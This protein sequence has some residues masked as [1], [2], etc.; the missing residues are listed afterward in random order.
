MTLPDTGPER[1]GGL[2]SETREMAEQD[3][4]E[5]LGSGPRG[6]V[7]LIVGALIVI[8]VLVWLLVR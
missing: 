7:V 6:R 3:V 5:A 4:M 8:A 1:P 2:S